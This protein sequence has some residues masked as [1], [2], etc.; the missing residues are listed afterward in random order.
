MSYTKCPACGQDI[1]TDETP[2]ISTQCLGCGAVVSVAPFPTAPEHDAP[3]L[4]PNGRS[5]TDAPPL[6]PTS[7]TGDAPPPLPKSPKTGSAPP[8]TAASHLGKKIVRGAVIGIAI[9]V[10]GVFA[11]FGLISA[12]SQNKGDLKEANQYNTPIEHKTADAET[13][14]K[15]EQA[16]APA[17]QTEP[18]PTPS[19]KVQSTVLWDDFSS[20]RVAAEQKY[21]DKIISVTGSVGK[22]MGSGKDSTV[23]LTGRDAIIGGG[24]IGCSLAASEIAKVANLKDGSVI[25]V[26]GH[27]TGHEYFGFV[28]GVRLTGCRIV[29]GVSEVKAANT[30]PPSAITAEQVVAQF[31]ENEVAAGQRFLQKT[32][33]ITGEVVKVEKDMWGNIQTLLRAGEQLAD[34]YCFFAESE[35][36]SV[37]QLSQSQHVAIKGLC[38]NYDTGLMG[39]GILRFKNCQ[40]VPEPSNVVSTSQD[41]SSGQNTT[42]IN[43]QVTPPSHNTEPKSTPMPKQTESPSVNTWTLGKWNRVNVPDDESATLEI[44]KKNGNSFSFTINARG[45]QH[46]G[47]IDEVAQIEVDKAVSTFDAGGCQAT[48]VRKGSS[49]VVETTGDECWKYAGGGTTYSGEYAPFEAKGVQSQT[50]PPTSL[51]PTAPETFNRN[52]QV[53]TVKVQDVLNVREAPTTDAKTVAQ[54]RA[55]TQVSVLESPMDKVPWVRIKETESGLQGWVHGEYLEYNKAASGA[56]NGVESNGGW[57]G[58]YE[59]D[60][61]APPNQNMGYAVTIHS[62]NARLIANVDISGFQTLHSYICS[63]KVNGNKLALSFEKYGPDN[64]GEYCQPG[65]TILTFEKANDGTIL[66][67]WGKLEAMLK[68]NAPN[69]NVYFKKLGATSKG[70]ASGGNGQ[71]DEATT[72]TDLKNSFWVYPAEDDKKIVINFLEDGK[73]SVAFIKGLYGDPNR[74]IVDIPATWAL[75]GDN[76]VVSIGPD[77]HVFELSANI[78]KEKSDGS[79]YTRLPEGTDY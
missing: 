73:A 66:T 12:T 53:A 29:S 61:F 14:Q 58:K 79:A 34:V 49:I 39:V 40:I 62:E 35:A 69:G 54:L 24:I 4:P 70:E 74:A 68:E 56:G 67:H 32:F 38:D 36:S 26:V 44:T 71:S 21:K 9:F 22:V 78:L 55:G 47:L 41:S 3:P 7:R 50:Q 18:I 5:S 13:R 25:E 20:N 51:P 8:T 59:F 76:I 72:S 64:I 63:T 48:F 37:A 65:D 17:M 6:L 42:P 28:E 33:T 75:D 46:A 52:S 19:V 23:F 1:S 60:E 57:E 16:I 43:E 45:G 30:A 31:R 10:V 15:A 11:L 27:C 2:G 77:K